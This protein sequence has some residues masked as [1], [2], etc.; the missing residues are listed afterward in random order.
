LS[1][2]VWAEQSSSVAREWRS[3]P[4]SAF[5]SLIH[6]WQT[7]TEASL[8]QLKMKKPQKETF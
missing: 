6:R 4:P 5:T 7:R 1:S 3:I 2:D 8:S